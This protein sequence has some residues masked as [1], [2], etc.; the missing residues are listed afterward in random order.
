MDESI[1]ILIK[2]GALFV[3]NH[4][5][6]KDSQA[7]LIRLREIVPES[8][9]LVI[10]ATLGE[11]EWTGTIEHIENTIGSIPLIIAS[12]PNKD[13]FGMVEH[14]KMWPSP[15]NRQCTSDLKRGPVER[16]IRKYLKEN[17]QYQN[18]II[19]CMGLRAEESSGRAKATVFKRNDRNSKAGREWY[20]WLPVHKLLIDEVFNNI[21]GANEL[22]HWAY[23]KGMSRL[24][25]CFCIM[26]SKSDL[27]IASKLMP[28]LFKKYCNYEKKLNMT[29]IMPSKGN[30]IFLPDIVKT[31]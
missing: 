18:R 15:K 12:N 16:E 22:P 14:R 27:R 13:F 19:N 8:Q 21:K 10:H 20:D 5:G 6:G 3:V 26:A 4:S 30:Q 17:P 2:K 28:E 31:Q 1:D 7:M 29:L 23:S 9:L 25:C 11:V 24:S